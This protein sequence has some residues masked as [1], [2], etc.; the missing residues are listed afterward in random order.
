MPSYRL[1]PSAEDDLLQIASYTI[2]TWGLDQASRY[3]AALQRCFHSL[4]A[5]TALTRS[6]IPSRP[7]LQVCKCEQHYVFVLR[8]EGAP[9]LIVAV[10]HHKLDLM[11]RLRERLEGP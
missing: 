6:P 11:V 5:G 2:E 7:E 8:E 10:L 3:E 9:V 4:A 1:T